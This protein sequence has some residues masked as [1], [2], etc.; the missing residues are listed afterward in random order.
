MKPYVYIYTRTLV[1]T[2]SQEINPT[3][4]LSDMNVHNY[5]YVLEF[6]G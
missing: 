5:I 3:H 2:T 1:V 4:F 6:S